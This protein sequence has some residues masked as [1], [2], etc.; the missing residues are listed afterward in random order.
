MKG[1]EELPLHFASDKERL[2]QNQVSRVDLAG[3]DGAHA[4]LGGVDI[5]GIVN[6]VRELE[7]MLEER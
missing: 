5:C 6:P 4:T 2:H 7:D 1:G 3:M